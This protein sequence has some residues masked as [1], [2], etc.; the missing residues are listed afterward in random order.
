MSAHR[1]GSRDEWTKARLDLLAAEKDL[2]RRR[3]ELAE[4]RRALPWVPIDEQYTFDGSDGTVTLGG[5]FDGHSQLL[6][7]TSSSTSHRRAATRVNSSGRWL[8]SAATTRTPTDS[9]SADRARSGAQR[10]AFGGRACATPL[11]S[12]GKQKATPTPVRSIEGR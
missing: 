4:R 3:D 11:D 10:P 2:N 1:T 6:A 5:L 9:C 12:C 7:P 8:G